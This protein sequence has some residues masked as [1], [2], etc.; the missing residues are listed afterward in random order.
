MAKEFYNPPD[1]FSPVAI[2]SHG[3]RSGRTVTL[4]GQAP[5][6]DDGSVVGPGEPAAQCG[7]VFVDLKKTLDLA[8]ATFQDAVYVRAYV[9]DKAVLPVL[10]RI[11]AEIFGANRPAFTPVIVPSVRA[12]GALVPLAPLRAAPELPAGIGTRMAPE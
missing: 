2:Y 7:R 8:G 11:A 1:V 4:A 5:L 12:A 10:Q 6:D 9:T 3:V